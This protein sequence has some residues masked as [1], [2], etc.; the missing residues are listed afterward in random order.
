MQNV[1]V[2]RSEPTLNR[3]M[4]APAPQAPYSQHQASQEACTDRQ[5]VAMLDSYR[6]SGGLARSQEV[7]ALFKRRCGSDLAALASWIIDKK[8][9]CFEWQSKMWLPLFQ[10][11]HLDMTPQPGLSRVLA[12]L[13]SRYDAW[14]LANWFAQSNAWLGERTP[15][16]MLGLDPSAVLNA[17]RA[18]RL[19]ANG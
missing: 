16:D 13:T 18:D 3:L 17:A 14:E 10:F 15:A 4:F 19:V 12:E 2:S 1:L 7:A 9:I 6:A 8:V 11:N 5:F